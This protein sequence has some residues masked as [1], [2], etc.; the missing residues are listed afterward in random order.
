MKLNDVLIA[1]LKKKAQKTEDDFHK[2]FESLLKK[3]KISYYVKNHGLSHLKSDKDKDIAKILQEHFMALETE[4][5]LSE[6]NRLESY[7][8]NKEYY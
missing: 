3:Y 1:Q 2:E 5:F 6:L 7:F 4:K 8:E